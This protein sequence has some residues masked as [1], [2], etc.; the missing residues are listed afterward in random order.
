MR[1]VDVVSMANPRHHSPSGNWSLHRFILPPGNAVADSLSHDCRQ[2]A[3]LALATVLACV[4]ETVANAKTADKNPL[5]RCSEG[6]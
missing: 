5:Q 1:S 6:G 2:L 4:E 3:V